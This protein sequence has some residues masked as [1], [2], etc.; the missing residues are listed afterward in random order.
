VSL[1]NEEKIVLFFE[2][3]Q[4]ITHK[5]SGS[6]FHSI[7]QKKTSENRQNKIKVSNSRFSFT[8]CSFFPTKQSFDAFNQFS[9]QKTNLS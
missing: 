5:F 7:S 2:N 3:R 6:F 8:K 9:Y 4:L 1:N